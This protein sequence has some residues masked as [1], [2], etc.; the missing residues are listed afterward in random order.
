M[1]AKDLVDKDCETLTATIASSGT[2]SSV[3]NLYGCTAIGFYTPAA[4]TGTS[5]TFLGSMENDGTNEVTIRDSSNNIVTYTVAV[6]S[7]YPLDADIFA[8]YSTIKIV[9]NDTEA[10][11]RTIKIKP[12]AI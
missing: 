3:V 6:D 2:E 11:A 10:A 5:F 1:Q 12:F 7:G 4:L 8:P 9:S